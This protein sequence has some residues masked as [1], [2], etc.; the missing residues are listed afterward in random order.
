[1]FCLASKGMDRSYELT[2]RCHGRN[3]SAPLEFRSG[4]KWPMVRSCLRRRLT[5]RSSTSMIRAMSLLVSL[6][7]CRRCSSTFFSFLSSRLE[8][9]FLGLGV[10]VVV[11][12]GVGSGGGGSAVVVVVVVTTDDDAAI[13]AACC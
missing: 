3:F 4:L 9:S 1:M 7:A 11:V 2:S 10:P 12:V 5:V 13:M 8:L 6:G